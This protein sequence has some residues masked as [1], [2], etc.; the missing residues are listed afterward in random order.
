MSKREEQKLLSDISWREKCLTLPYDES[1]ISRLKKEIEKLKEKL[2]NKDF[3][4]TNNRYDWDGFCDSNFIEKVETA[5]HFKNWKI[6]F[7]KIGDLKE[8]KLEEDFLI[9]AEK[10]IQD[11]LQKNPEIYYRKKIVGVHEYL[12]Y[13]YSSNKRLM[14]FKHCQDCTY[15]LNNSL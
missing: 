12:E 7:E 15:C 8:A 14:R 5:E 2:E 13:G 10:I 1:T 11:E 6:A 9:Q 3:L 4:I